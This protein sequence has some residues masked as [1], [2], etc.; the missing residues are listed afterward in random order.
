MTSRPSQPR[1]SFFRKYFL[2]LFAAVVVPLLANG[3]SEAWLGYRD[4]RARLDERLGLEARA[5]AGRIEGFVAGIRDQLGWMVQLP[6]TDG[7]EDQRR[8]DALRLLRQVPA[9][10][11]LTL[12]DGV[13]RERLYVSRV[14]L[15]RINAGTDR[16]D[17]PAV[18]GARAARVWYGPVRYHHG[19]EPF[20]RIA[21]AGNRAAVGV[22]VA[23]I[24]L[25]LIWD[26]ISAI[27]VGDTGQAFVL[28]GPGRL[29]AHPDIGIVLRGADDPTARTLQELR[30]AII[31]AAGRAATG[32]DVEG[33][34][35]MAAMAPVPGVDWTVVVEQPLVE[36]FGPI[37]AALWRTAALLLA[38][39]AL[40]AA[41]AYWLARRMT[42]PIRVLEEGTE[43]IGAGQFDH[44]I[45]ITT[46]DELERL[47]AHFN[48]MAKELA[49]SQE[50]SERIDRLKRFL[51]PQL[52]EL[53]E[54]TG[55]SR[56]LEGQ[57][58]EVAVVFCDLR[59][60]TAFSNK[61]EPEEIIA[62]LNE[63]YSMLGAVVT[64]HEGTLTSFQGDGLMIILNAPIPCPDPA[65]RAVRMAT[66]MQ[67]NIQPLIQ[68][69][70]ARGDVIGVGV[71]LAFGAATV[72]QIGTGSRLEYTAIGNVVNL[73][74]RLC[75]SAADGEIL[76]DVAI[77]RE[78]GTT[79]PTIALGTRPLKGYD[80]QVPVFA[81]KLPTLSPATSAA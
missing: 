60:F 15:D 81:V 8:I 74:A 2:A 42:G 63:Y 48:N 61:A 18:E 11:D 62:V 43:R 41:F 67:E 20:M 3:G 76:F 64:R 24:N 79:L 75:A 29:I 33:R 34:T 36:A 7:P 31:G 45:T 44:R 54:R 70:R 12:V 72:G 55:E 69:W 56:M 30:A 13:S 47:A 17:D 50:R 73:A 35:V 32:T 22:A 39:T 1:R 38:G 78:V 71:G 80:Q 46:G 19:S 65:L 58:T 6:W 10:S 40:S 66:E 16:S 59:G 21:V 37:Y 4:Q 51:A 23:E 26:V 5:A 49:V 68:R 9:I 57:R 27:R 53:V 28:D 14:G 77:A 52:A 25:K